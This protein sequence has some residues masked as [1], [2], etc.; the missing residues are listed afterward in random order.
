ML[1]MITYYCGKGFVLKTK[2]KKLLL[3]SGPREKNH[4]ICLKTFSETQ[5]PIMCEAGQG[6]ERLQ[7]QDGV[8][9]I[10]VRNILRWEIF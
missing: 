10:Q 1:G 5:Y 7:W 2:K 3:A 6:K 8:G 9:N 4:Y